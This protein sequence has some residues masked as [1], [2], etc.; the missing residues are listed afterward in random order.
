MLSPRIQ[1]PEENID[2]FL[3][4]LNRLASDCNF[5]AVNADKN[6]SSLIH[7]SF[8]LGTRSGVV[9]TRLLENKTLT[10]DKAVEQARTL[11]QGQQTA[12]SYIQPNSSVTSVKM[13]DRLP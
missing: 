1:K 8:I 10:L 9:H 2:E 3:Q 11:E 6:R 4:T 13:N 5:Q 7:Y 12:D